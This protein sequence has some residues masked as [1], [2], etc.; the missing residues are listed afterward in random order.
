VLNDKCEDKGFTLK[1][2]TGLRYKNLNTD[3][4]EH[5]I[6]AALTFE[7]STFSFLFS[8]ILPS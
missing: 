7:L 6:V 5:F 8:A 2:K 4:I 1:L 3:I